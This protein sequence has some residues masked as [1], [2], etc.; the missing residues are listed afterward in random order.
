M[1]FLEKLETFA[2]RSPA[3]LQTAVVKL[4]SRLPW[5]C[6]QPALRC[7][8]PAPIRARTEPSRDPASRAPRNGQGREGWGEWEGDGSEGGCPGRWVG[9][10]SGRAGLGCNAPR[11]KRRGWAAEREERRGRGGRAQR[12]LKAQPGA[13][14]EPSG[15]TRP[16]VGCARA[17]LRQCTASAEPGKRSPAA[18][19]QSRAQPGARCRAPGGRKAA[20]ARGVGSGPAAFGHG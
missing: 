14:P 9:R 4:T 19:V 20:V 15:L 3:L 7:Q 2:R 8:R 10:D 16:P 5:H 11:Y 12:D 18:A 13:V 1:E 6:P 17:G